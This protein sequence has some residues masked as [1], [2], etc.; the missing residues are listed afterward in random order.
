MFGPIDKKNAHEMDLELAH[1]QNRLLLA[2]IDL[3]ERASHIGLWDMAIAY[4]D[5]G[6]PLYSFTYS[7]EMRHILGYSDETD[8]PNKFS[9]WNDRLHPD[10]NAAVVDAYEKYLSDKTGETHYDVEYRLKKKNSE[11]AYFH[12][13]CDAFR[14]E[15]GNIT[16][17]MGALIETTEKLRLEKLLQAVNSAIDLLL[18]A[19]VGEFETALWRSMGMMAHAVNADRVRL[20]RNY[21]ENGEL[22][23]TQMYEWSEGAEPQQGRR[24]TIGVSYKN[25]LPGWEDKLSG[26]Q[27]INSIVRDMSPKEQA[28][29]T[30]QGILSLLMIPVFLRDKFWGFV[31]FNDCHKERLFTAN[32]ESILW[33]GS[34]LITNAL[35]RNEMTQELA[36]ALDKAQEASRAKSYFLSNM[37]HEIRTPI[38]AIVGMTRIGKTAPNVEKK[39]YA[40][41]KIED[42]SAHLLGVIN[43]I[44][45]MSKIEANK[46]ELSYTEF[47]F[48]KMLQMVVNI[49]GF[50]VNEKNQKFFVNLD[51]KIPKRLV[52]DDQRLAQ[53]I[54]NLLSNAV[55]FTPELG[56]IIMDLRLVGEDND[57]CTIEVSV[58]DTGIGVSPEQ[59]KRLFSSFEQAESNTSRKFG[60]TGLGLAI[61]KYI[62]ELMNGEIWVVSELGKGAEFAFS[63]KL[64]RASEEQPQLSADVN[65]RNIRIFAVDDELETKEFF[66][67]LAQRMGIHCDIAADGRDA[68]AML[69]GTERYDIYFVGW[70]MTG[71]NGVDL[72]REIRAKGIT[73]PI[74]IMVSAYEWISVE[75]DAKSAG[76]NGFLAKPLFPS[77]LMDCLNSNIGIIGSS[78][79]DGVASDQTTS[80]KG[81]YILLAEDVEINREI[82]QALLEPTQVEIDNA[83]NGLEAV[84]LFTVSPQ[85]YD[86]I[87]MDIQM[88]EMDGYEATR[89]IRALDIEKAGSIPIIAMTANVFKEDIERCL[90]AG[91]NAHVGKPIDFDELLDVIKHYFYSAPGQPL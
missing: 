16:R 18:Q 88:P 64:G 79:A 17:V 75:H 31:G 77:S 34:L 25:D 72:A 61:S 20:W 7:D 13:F 83:V 63:V 11:Y 86:L 26:G 90:E 27:C 10:D 5:S 1:E 89:R 82:V 80:F 49:I 43:D 60:G 66:S 54:T 50:R 38:N 33:S 84:R 6:E 87:L 3:M 52:G 23:C 12:D 85:R 44:L 68:L 78:A 28:R 47:D 4:D 45:D 51:P 73:E 36:S 58:T 81:C 74:C 53:V 15:Y 30:P 9:S 62:I 59:Q 40:F 91:M 21:T 76:I 65:I 32:E 42:A 46:F 41:G 67:A 37:S 55:K 8:F 19:Q 69:S 24:I 39:D 22:Y 71:I 2:K 48:E 70:K 29:F 14:D 56:T 35:L 57:S